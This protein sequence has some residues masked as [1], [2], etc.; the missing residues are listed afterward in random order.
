MT[1]N[2]FETSILILGWVRSVHPM[3]LNTAHMIDWRCH[4]NLHL[5][6]GGIHPRHIGYI[7]RGG[8][9][10]IAC[11]TYDELYRQAELYNDVPEGIGPGEGGSFNTVKPPVS[12]YKYQSSK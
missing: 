3:S 6:I 11:A 12:F 5:R 4:R 2:E 1:R 8:H 10:D 7:S 9:M